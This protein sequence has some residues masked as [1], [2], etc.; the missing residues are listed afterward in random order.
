MIDTTM[1]VRNEARPNLTPPAPFNIYFPAIYNFYQIFISRL[2]ITFGEENPFCLKAVWVS[3]KRSLPPARQATDVLRVRGG[4]LNNDSIAQKNLQKMGL[5]W[6]CIGFELALFFLASQLSILTYQS[7]KKALTEI[8]Q[9][10]RLALFSQTNP[11]WNGKIG[12]KEVKKASP[13]ACIANGQ[14]NLL[15]IVGLF[16]RVLP[17]CVRPEL[18]DIGMLKF[19]LL[20]KET[21][22]GNKGCN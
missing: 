5:N 22:D 16:N 4:E 2:P 19:K 11:F 1:I 7:A 9:M 6:L 3:T 14:I 8:F 15:T 20:K 12:L 10:L 21:L 18:G 13:L 17:R